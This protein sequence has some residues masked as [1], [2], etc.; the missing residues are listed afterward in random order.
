MIYFRWVLTSYRREPGG[1]WTNVENECCCTR[2]VNI[3][4]VNYTSKIS[5]P[6]WQL[7]RLEHSALIRRWGVRV[8]LR[9]RH[10]LSQKFWHFHKNT[11]SCVENE[12]CCP[13]TVN[14]SN[15]KFTL[16]TCYRRE[17]EDLWTNA[18]PLH[19]PLVK[20]IRRQYGMISA[21]FPYSHIL[22]PLYNS[23]SFRKFRPVWSISCTCL[24]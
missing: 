24:R 21:S 15:V 12:C 6:P 11:R 22:T 17:P 10:F 4:N 19:R 8:P 5:I 23:D 9:S 7:N 3:S 14:I 18:A 20:E 1:L 13:R 2:T 16:K